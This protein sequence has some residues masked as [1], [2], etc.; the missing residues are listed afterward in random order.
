ME[1]STNLKDR[2]KKRLYHANRRVVVRLFYLK[3]FLKVC[4]W[5]HKIGNKD[6]TWI[7]MEEFLHREFDTETTHGICPECVNK[8][9]SEVI[10]DYDGRTYLS[11]NNRYP[12]DINEA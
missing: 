11:V 9:Q 12:G 5:C 1:E 6:D 10:A 3:H 4:A 2:R 7:T 8:L